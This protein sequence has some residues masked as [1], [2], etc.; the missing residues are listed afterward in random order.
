MDTVGPDAWRRWLDPLL[1]REILRLRSR[2]QLSLDEFRGLY[3]SDELVDR[4]LA[5]QAARAAPGE[6]G[7]DGGQA[8]LAEVPPCPPAATLDLDALETRLLL[9]ALAPEIDLKYETLYA[10]LNDDVTRKWPTLDLAQRL[11]GPGADPHDVARALSPDASLLRQGI[12]VRIQPP[13]A[14]PSCLNTGFAPSCAVTQSLLGLPV[15]DPQLAGIARHDRPQ[16]AWEALA[17]APDCIAHLRRVAG[18]LHAHGGDGPAVLL[19]GR[20]GSG[21]RKVADA[22]CTELG[23]GVWRIDVGAAQALPLAQLESLLA[24]L[25]LVLRLEP[26][27]LYLHDF[28]AEA[29]EAHAPAADTLRRLVDGL[30]CQPVPVFAACSGEAGFPGVRPGRRRLRIQ[31]E[32]LG[33]QHRLALW[34]RMLAQ[35]GLALPDTEV[36]ELADRLSLA[37]AE[38][39][40]AIASA[41]DQAAL[42]PPAAVDGAMIMAA[43]RQETDARIGGAALKLPP[44]HLWRELV[45]PDAAH[46]RLREFAAAVRHRHV[47]YHDWGF[48]RRVGS[49]AGIKA[50]FSGP[51]GTGKT[52]AAGIVAGELGYDL[53]RIELSQLVSKYIGETEKNLDR[54]FAAVHAANAMLFIDEA[55]AILG[56][57]SEVKDAHDRYANIEVAYLLQKLEEHEGVV[58]LASN[59][60][61]NIDDAFARRMQYVIEFPMPDERQRELLWRGMFPDSVPVAAD[62]DWEFLARQFRI[63]GGDIRNVALDAAFLAAGAGEALGMR[64]LMQAM[65]RQLVKQGRAPT[66]GEF[67]QY[68]PLVSESGAAP[69]QAG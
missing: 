22:F 13:S 20:S 51:S 21:R 35:A 36:R 60:K 52:M 7:P 56:K 50:L 23:L 64:Q 61:R 26:A 57:R 65:A 3:V 8:E 67:R 9:L 39:G 29:G 31:L 48:A 17:Q 55:E 42:A 46:R 30:L 44:G 28:P 27:V 4:L 68:L 37:P 66:A 69:A 59:L 5:A 45:L 62:V 10:Y 16:L 15:T 32:G 58:V 54:V 12:L 14:R 1:E 41:R 34:Q 11:L 53:Y 47:V 25:S 24:T 33:F 18:L 43:A 38:V 2:Y 6:S 63:A 49:A 19:S 40:A